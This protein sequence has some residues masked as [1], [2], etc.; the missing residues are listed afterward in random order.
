MLPGVLAAFISNRVDSGQQTPVTHFCKLSLN[1]A[2]PCPWPVAA[3]MSQKRP[4]GSQSQQDSLCVSRRD[5]EQPL[6]E[7]TPCLSFPIWKA[8]L[9][10][11]WQLLMRVG[12]PG[13]P[14]VVIAAVRNVRGDVRRSA[15][16]VSGPAGYRLGP[17]T[18]DPLLA[19]QLGLCTST[20]RVQVPSLDG[21]L[22][23]Q[24]P[25]M[26]ENTHTQQK[27]RRCLQGSWL[28]LSY[29]GSGVR[30]SHSVSQCTK[31]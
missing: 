4:R 1:G 16:T 23:S 5:Y 11:L 6:T 28:L 14:G 18:G 29:Q 15:P 27:T 31:A 13:G 7:M 22:R 30:M 25:H 19:Q 24:K 9:A 17:S 10:F 8:P 3:F 21:E 2:Q 26:A 12:S 20:A